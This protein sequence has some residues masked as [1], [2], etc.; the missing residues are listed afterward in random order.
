MVDSRHIVVLLIGLFV[1]APA[2]FAFASTGRDALLTERARLVEAGDGPSFEY[3]RSL[4]FEMHGDDVAAARLVLAA[5]GYLPASG[6]GDPRYFDAELAGTVERFQR[7]NGL[8][9]DG[10]L[11]PVTG[12]L[13]SLGNRMLIARIDQTLSLPDRPSSGLVVV[14]NIAA[15]E[16]RVL[17]DGQT[18]FETRVIVG[19][20]SRQ[21]PTFEAVIDAVTFNPS[22]HVPADILRKDILPEMAKDAGYAQRRK[23]HVYARE[24]GSWIRIDPHS[25][26]WK[27]RPIGQSAGYRFVQRPHEGNALGRV[28]FE[29]ENPYGIYLH[30]TPDRHLFQRD[31][32]TFSSGCVRI[33]AALDMAR[34]LLGDDVWQVGRITERLNVG[35]TFRVSLPEPVS[36]QVEYRLAD[37]TANGKVRFLPDIYGVLP[38]SPPAIV[39]VVDAAPISAPATSQHCHNP[40]QA[41]LPNFGG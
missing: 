35:R 40:D 28:K 17:K 14:V 1:L 3:D 15:A 9:A 19:R 26:D 27:R 30:D 29:M 13:L 5:R 20:P 22:W 37:V 11:G 38:V 16:L 18:L 7:D 23:I 6:N 24:N 12:E 34:L 41:S 8:T 32:R 2:G 33:D 36:V 31:R 39:S 21:T 25:V 4:R 10:I